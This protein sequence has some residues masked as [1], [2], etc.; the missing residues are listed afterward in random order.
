MPKGIRLNR[1]MIAFI[2]APKNELIQRKL[3][4]VFARTVMHIAERTMFVRG[5]ARAV[6][7]ASC[8]VIGPAIITAPGDMILKNGSSI[9]RRV[10]NAP[11]RVNRNSAQSPKCCADSLWAISCRRKE[12]VKISARLNR[13]SGIINTDKPKARTA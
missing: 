13:V 8:L 10:M 2:H 1:A 11:N 6:F 4:R 9:E 12:N 3:F 5:P 7:P